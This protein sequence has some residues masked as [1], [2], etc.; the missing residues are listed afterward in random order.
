MKIMHK[1]QIDVRIKVEEHLAKDGKELV[2]FAYG[3][4]N[5]DERRF[6]VGIAYMPRNSNE[7]DGYPFNRYD[8]I[9]YDNDVD[10]LEYHSSY[11]NYENALIHMGQL[12]RKATYENK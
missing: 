6:Y 7:G 3:T 5:K 8:V 11:L 1:P 2:N 10:G 9:V 12:I 4:A